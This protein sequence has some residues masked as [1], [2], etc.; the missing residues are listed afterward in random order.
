MRLEYLRAVCVEIRA[1]AP[2]SFWDADLETLSRAWNGIGPE[3]WWG[4]LRMAVSWL[5]R[6]FSAASLIHDWEFSQPGK[7][8]AKFTAAN[9][10]LIEN[11]AREAIFNCHVGIIPCGIAAGVLCEIFGWRAYK[12]GKLK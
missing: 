1:K 5:L 12:E 10:H 4:W 2:S 6:P 11:I 9:A 8:F 3:Y 7:T